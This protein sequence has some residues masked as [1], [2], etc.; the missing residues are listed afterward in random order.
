VTYGPEHPA[1]MDDTEFSL[2]QQANQV[3]PPSA[4]A[5]R[6]CSDCPV[7]YFVEMRAAGCCDGFPK[8]R[9]RNE[10]TDERRMKWAAAQRRRRY[11]LAAEAATA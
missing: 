1:C 6:P 11:R 5:R 9:V 4:R 10:T 8:M 7:S 2:W 3:A